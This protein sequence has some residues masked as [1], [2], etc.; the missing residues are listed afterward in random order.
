M[1]GLN[2]IQR[3]SVVKAYLFSTET[4]LY[5]GEIFIEADKLEN[6]EGVTTLAPPAHETGTV[7]VFH[8]RRQEWAL[9]SLALFRQRFLG[10]EGGKS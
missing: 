3:R 1:N 10:E 8:I 2:D 4:G 7:P 6:E 5:E 9:V